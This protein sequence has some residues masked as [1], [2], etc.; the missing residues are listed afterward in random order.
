[1][2]TQDGAPYEFLI[3]VVDRVA[4][5]Y[6][7]RVAFPDPDSPTGVGEN[8]ITAPFDPENPALRAQLA[9]LPT[10]VIASAA[11][12]RLAVNQL[13]QTARDV[14]HRLFQAL[15]VGETLGDLSRLRRRAQ[16][17]GADVRVSLRVQPP[18]LAVLPWEYLFDARSD[19]RE[20]LGRACMLTRSSGDLSPVPSLEVPGPLRVL[21]MVSLPGDQDAL[22][23]EQERRHLTE[24]LA[25][26]AADGRM[27]LHWIP[28]TKAALQ[29]AVNQQHWH[30]FHY[31]GH[32]DFD[33][34]TGDGR[35]A[36][37]GPDG[38]TDFVTARQLSAMFG[39]HPTLRLVV[40]NACQSAQSSSEDRQSG[41]AAALVHAGLA[42]VVAMQ[43]PI[44]GGAAPVFS[45][46]GDFVA[47]VGADQRTVYLF[48]VEGEL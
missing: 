4:D 5:G 39:P 31:I 33:A 8:R 7:L 46:A 17:A 28:A 10:S 19:K 23:V 2:E 29:A 38:G 45:T 37:T 14:G 18:E 12:T 11:K 25:P 13:E 24:A 16:A 3:E 15:M 35:L 21:A 41:I 32:G 6:R 30:V 48:D 44:T 40:L 27:E 36:F 22:D 34:A 43:F 47:L 20:F 42:A 1:M 9:L 26:M